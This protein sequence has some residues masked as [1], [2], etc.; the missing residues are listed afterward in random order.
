LHAVDRGR[1]VYRLRASGES[2]DGNEDVSFLVTDGRE[3]ALATECV[4]YIV[5]LGLFAHIKEL[6][7]VSESFTEFVAAVDIC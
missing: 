6:E 3:L 2:R 1:Q 5:A 7:P 4:D